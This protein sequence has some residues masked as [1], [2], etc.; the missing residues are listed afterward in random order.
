MP[1]YDYI[2]RHDSDKPHCSNLPRELRVRDIEDIQWAPG[3]ANGYNEAP[4]RGILFGNWNEFSHRAV[5][6]LEKAG[7]VLEW[8]DEWSTC[9]DCG[10]AIRTQPDSYSWMP[11][12]LLGD[13]E[14]LCNDCADWP[15]YLRGI[16]NDPRKAC[17]DHIDPEEYGY[18]RLS[19]EGEYENGFHPGQDD[20]PEK[21]LERL[22]ARGHRNVLFRVSGVGQFDVSFEAWERPEETDKE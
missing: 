20:N 21:I 15:E 16:E 19:E 7:Y 22:H 4:K 14:I 6:L 9:S 11:D 13:G 17:M 8:E 18:V 1:S 10:R 2:L 3:Y 5:A 12:Y